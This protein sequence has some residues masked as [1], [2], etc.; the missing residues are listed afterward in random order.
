ML[1]NSVHADSGYSIFNETNRNIQL[2][3]MGG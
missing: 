3:S 2:R 1:A